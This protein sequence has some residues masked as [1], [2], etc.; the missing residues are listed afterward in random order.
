MYNAKSDGIATLLLHGSCLPKQ[1][2][3]H[4]WDD[5]G[6]TYVP[7]RTFFV[8]DQFVTQGL[9]RHIEKT[10]AGLDNDHL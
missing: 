2:K 8:V 10:V 7:F 6:R 5:H 1:T 3:K 9:V 4:T